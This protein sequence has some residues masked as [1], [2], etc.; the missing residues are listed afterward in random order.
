MRRLMDD[1]AYVDSV[2]KA[3]NE[4]ANDLAAPVLRDVQ[5]IIGCL[6]P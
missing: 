3:G 6:M 1:P 4:K 2:L 5:K